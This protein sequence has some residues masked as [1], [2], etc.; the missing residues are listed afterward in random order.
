MD[1]VAI[2]LFTQQVFFLLNTFNTFE[3]TSQ[4][5]VKYECAANMKRM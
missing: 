5:V 3:T 1:V 4:P 2:M